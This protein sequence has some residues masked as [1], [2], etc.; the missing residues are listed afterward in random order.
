MRAIA[1]RSAAVTDWLIRYAAR[2]AVATERLSELCKAGLTSLCEVNMAWAAYHGKTGAEH[3][4]KWNNLTKNGYRITSLS[5]YGADDN[6]D[7][8]EVRYAAVWVKQPGPPQTGFHGNSVKEFQGIYDDNVAKGFHPVIFTAT[9]RRGDAICAGVFEQTAGPFPLMRVG[10]SRGEYFDEDW[11]HTAAGTQP[12]DMVLRCVA[13]YGRT[14]HQGVL[15]EDRTTYSAIW[16]PNPNQVLCHTRRLLSDG[17]EKQAEFKKTFDSW[18]KDFKPKLR[19]SFV[20]ITGPQPLL[21]NHS[22]P[23]FGIEHGLHYFGVFRS[24]VIGLFEV[25]I[26][27]DGATYNAEVANLK[28]EGFRPDVIQGYGKIGEEHYAAIFVK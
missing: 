3:Q 18:T 15:A 27:M 8:D 7:V 16:D 6:G 24:N 21:K 13:I 25:R 28:K 11:K 2:P 22:G 4:T 10:M 14:K 12:G 23:T 19:P 26:N 1:L 5:V 17:P 20:T 9:G